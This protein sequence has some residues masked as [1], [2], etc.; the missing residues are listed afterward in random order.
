MAASAA[1]KIRRVHRGALLLA[2]AALA[3]C[4]RCGGPPA[5]RSAEELLPAQA[6]GAFVTAAL[7]QVARHADELLTRTAQ[8]PGGEQ[9]G[10]SR[11]A[12][13]AQLGFDPLSRQGL[14]SAGLD[15]DRSAAFVLTQAEGKRP[16][17]VAALPLS[18]PQAFARGLDKLARERAGYA[19]RTE[20]ARGNV[21]AVVFSRPGGAQKLAYAVVRGYGVVA[22]G[23]DPGEDLAA[24][25]ARLPDQSLAKEA[26]FAAARAALAGAGA[27]LVGTP[28][29]AS[30]APGGSAAPGAPAAVAPDLVFFAAA[31]GPVQTRLF[32]Q[33]L[34][35]YVA[36]GISAGPGGLV[37][38]GS[39][40]LA[41]PDAHEVAALLPGGGEA[42][43]ALLPRDAPVQ[44]RLG[45]QPAQLPQALSRVP[46]LREFLS[47]LRAA[48]AEKKVDLDSDLFGALQPGVVAALSLSPT[49]NLARA[50]DADLL[51]LRSHSPFDVVHLAVYAGAADAAR[52]RPA[53]QA[54]ADALPRFGAAATRSQTGDGVEWLVTSSGGQGARFGL[55]TVGG[56]ALAY[57]V[58]GES[59]EAALARKD[60][61]GAGGGAAALRID[62]GQLAAQVAALPQSAYGTGPQSYVARSLVGQVIEP[63]RPLAMRATI[64]PGAQGLL[65]ELTVAIA[66]AASADTAR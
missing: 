19:E 22:R 18:D 36:L 25:A 16:G 12:V 35:G 23:D 47:T 45:L 52:L 65:V 10:D 48:L 32:G 46:A 55:R 40:S 26:R 14:L 60:G 29:G 15:P 4:G 62:F 5:A 21:K 49:A 44:L 61:Q 20:E 66:Q 37:L 57:L 39:L 43:A 64:A 59:L 63:L 41:A 33:P 6:P 50:V 13:A 8:L 3:S 53:L 54:V 1:G 31:Q 38:R 2:A 58:G 51:D 7:S 34:P 27:P 9:I 17:F 56:T 24:A 42:L 11:K 28:P 30:G